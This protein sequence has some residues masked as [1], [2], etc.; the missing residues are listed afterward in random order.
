MGALWI[1]EL[2]SYW[3]SRFE[4]LQC[5]AVFSVVLLLFPLG[6]D[7]EPELLRLMAPAV[8]WGSALLAC[9]FGL[10]TLFR[11]DLRE[12][13]LEQAQTSIWPL[14]LLLALRMV[15]HWMFT[16]VPVVLA[17]V[18]GAAALGMSEPG[19][20]AVGW[21]LLLGT[22]SLVALGSVA[23]ALTANLTGG[24]MLSALLVLPLYVPVLIFGASA[25][26]LAEAGQG[27]DASLYLMGCSLLLS[28]L[29]AP[30]ASAAALKV[31]AE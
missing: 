21:S 25:I 24:A 15:A 3:Q 27:T 17:G 16:G 29:L 9:V 14:P 30:L 5:L 6:V 2:R 22:P 20:R 8:I 18:L 10:E 26:A 1:R 13:W 19:I 11:Q 7:P 31:V 23:A 12:G 4:A 28:I